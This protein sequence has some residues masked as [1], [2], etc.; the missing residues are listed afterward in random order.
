MDIA[1]A[2]P[3]IVYAVTGVI[4]RLSSLFLVHP[5]ESVSPPSKTH[6]SRFLCTLLYL[7]LHFV[8]ICHATSSSQCAFGGGGG[9]CLPRPRS[10]QSRSS[11]NMNIYIGYIVVPKSWLAI[12]RICLLWTLSYILARNNTYPIS[13]C[14]ISPSK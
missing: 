10:F 9:L 12:F 6:C 13:L 11:L 4:F 5:V 14:R 1:F 8:R 2:L 3:F 7:G